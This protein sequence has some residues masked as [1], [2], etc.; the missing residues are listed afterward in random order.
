MFS[1]IFTGKTL[2]ERAYSGRPMLKINDSIKF[3]I[4]VS[5]Y[6]VSLTSEGVGMDYTFDHLN[7]LVMSNFYDGTLIDTFT[8]II[9]IIAMMPIIIKA[10]FGVFG[11]VLDIT[12]YYIMSPA[13]FATMALGKDVTNKGKTSESTPI[14]TKW[15]ETIIKKTI[16]VF[17]Y[18]VAFQFFFILVPF[19]REVTFITDS[20]IFKC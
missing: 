1:K 20:S 3:P 5:T 4:G 15:L 2:T 11:R 10:L 8:L 14:Y 9:A 19:I 16:S 6:A 7:G 18:V 12:V 13:M 17:A